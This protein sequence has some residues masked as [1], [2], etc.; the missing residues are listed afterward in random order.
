MEIN[1]RT[2]L[3]SEAHRLWR[4]SAERRSALRGVIARE[5]SLCGFPVASVQILDEEGARALGKP[6]GQYYTLSFERFFPRGEAG[7]SS[8]VSALAEL[9]RR[10]LAGHTDGTVLI[11]ALGN[12]DI[13]PDAL[14]S[15]CAEGLLVTRHLKEARHPLFE[16]F[17]SVA[18]CRTG[19]LG[20]SG[21]ESALQIRALCAS[22]RP[23]C[24]IAVDALAGAEPEGLCRCVQVSSGGIAPGSGVG[25]DRERL[26][27]ETLGV[28]VVAVG[29]PTVIDAAR[30]A[31]EAALRGLFVTPRDIDTLVRRG[32]RLIACALDLALHEGLT[33]E[34][35]DSLLE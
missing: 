8:S 19:V 29:I 27:N 6:P 12:P 26:D 3:A 16:P 15:L 2:D 21:M 28:P 20:T 17:A 33:L 35:L 1:V 9:L 24:V 25:N 5:E 4:G 11:A 32:A 22:L 30:C 14:G 13:T 7:F 34:E 10:C 18:L 31:D 23:S